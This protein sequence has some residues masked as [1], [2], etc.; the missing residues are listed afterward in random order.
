M[1]DGHL[2]PESWHHAPEVVVYKRSTALGVQDVIEPLGNVFK[3]I[4]K[5][6]PTPVWS[7]SDP[8]A[9][10]PKAKTMVFT[11]PKS[12]VPD[13]VWELFSLWN[14]SRLMGLPVRAGGLEDQPVA[15]RT[16]FPIFQHE[17]QVHQIRSGSGGA[18]QT[19]VRVAGMMLQGLFGAK[20]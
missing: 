11:C 12:A 16:A 15:V 19:A 2:V 4:P 7:F 20:K 9:Q 1:V 18:E 13:A 8:T 17:Y 10:D 6:T 5:K 3:A 14:E